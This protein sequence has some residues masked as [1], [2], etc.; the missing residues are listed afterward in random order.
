MKDDFRDFGFCLLML[1]ALFAVMFW[2]GTP[3]HSQTPGRPACAPTKGLIEALKKD[4]GETVTAGGM[5]DQ[6]LVVILTNKVTGTF[7]ILVR[8][9]DGI[10]CIMAGGTGFALADPAPMK[11]HGL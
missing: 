5:I 3:A 7:T 2:I 10:A 9:T 8:N 11:G 1:S 4:Y 6:Q